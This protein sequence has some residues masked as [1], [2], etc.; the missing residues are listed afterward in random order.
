MDSDKPRVHYDELEL[1]DDEH[2]PD[3]WL[4]YYRGELFSGIAWNELQGVRTEDSM[5][6]GELHGRC[7]RFH[8]NGQC[9]SEGTYE[10]GNPVGEFIAWY[11]S[12]IMESYYRYSERYQTE[13]QRRYSEAGVM[14]FESDAARGLGHQRW[15]E[16]GEL[17]FDSYDGAATYYAPSGDW[18]IRKQN[19]DEEHNDDVLYD[20]AYAMFEIDM[21]L[22]RYPLLGW[23][24]GKLDAAEPRAEQLLLELVEH[25][26]IS[27]AETALESIGKRSLVAAIP[28]VRRMTQSERRKDPAAG[29]FVGTFAELAEVVL[30][31]LTET[32][33]QQ[34]EAK[35]LALRKQR[36][37]RR[38]LEKEQAKRDEERHRQI[39]PRAEAAF[40]E[41]LV[42]ETTLKSGDQIFTGEAKHRSREYWHIFKYVVSGRTYK[43]IVTGND[44]EPPASVALRYRED[45]PADYVIE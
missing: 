32:D 8:A 28:L 12:G 11:P 10:H 3:E 35:L 44:P 25:S 33:E 23:L 37:H 7:V 6:D 34:R 40:H 43:A 16:S 39:W 38:R 42:G 18:A 29:G 9:A 2:I 27:V 41:T 20:H 1:V 15:Y 36:A 17:L 45:N 26:V 30:V 22:V 13:V 4:A 21:G 31:K 5:K 19:G 24:H 14:I